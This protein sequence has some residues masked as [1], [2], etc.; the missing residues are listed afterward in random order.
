M[1][2]S[3]ISYL[4]VI[5]I[6]FTA[7]FSFAAYNFGI[8]FDDDAL[9]FKQCVEDGVGNISECIELTKEASKISNVLRKISGISLANP[10]DRHDV[11][12]A[13]LYLARYKYP[14]IIGFI[15]IICTGIFTAMIIKALIRSL[16]SKP[17]ENAAT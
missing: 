17:K 3:F 12:E 16:K 10:Q 13:S 2:I 11:N 4:C 6:L 7:H 15:G 1:K 8:F 14:L 5:N 9:L